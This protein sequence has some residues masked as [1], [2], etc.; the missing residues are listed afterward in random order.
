MEKEM[1]LEKAKKVLENVN[2]YLEKVRSG[3]SESET[4]Y[5]M[6]CEATMVVLENLN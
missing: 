4:A 3:N 1:T 6:L 2:H 5:D